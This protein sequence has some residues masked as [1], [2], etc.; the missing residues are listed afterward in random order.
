[1]NAISIT[2]ICALVTMAFCLVLGALY[3]SHPAVA[4]QDAVQ[5]NGVNRA[6]VSTRE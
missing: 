5:Q 2:T 4:A 1:M 3:G 6:M